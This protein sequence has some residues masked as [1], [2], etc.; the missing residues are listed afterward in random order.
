MQDYVFWLGLIVL[1]QVFKFGA[2]N[3]TVKQGYI[4]EYNNG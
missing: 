1:E 3:N 2:P 4:Q